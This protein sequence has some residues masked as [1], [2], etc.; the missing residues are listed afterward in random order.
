MLIVE[1][2]EVEIDYC[3]RCRGVWLDEGELELLAGPSQHDTLWAATQSS[4]QRNQGAQP[5]KRRRCPRC[6]RPIELIALGSDPKLELDRCNEGH[7]LWFDQGELRQLLTQLG[8][9]AGPSVRLLD[10]L[11]ARPGESQENTKP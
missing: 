4:P 6:S 11:F 1:L 9:E 2:H 3:D 8:P 5:P 7:G 10:E